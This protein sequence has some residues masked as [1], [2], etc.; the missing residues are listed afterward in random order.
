DLE[1]AGQRQPVGL[2]V[3]ADEQV[4]P[5]HSARLKPRLGPAAEAAV[6]PFTGR[7]RA[8]SLLALIGAPSTYPRPAR[9]E[10]EVDSRGD[11]AEGEHR[12][13]AAELHRRRRHPGDH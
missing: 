5:T 8:A 12:V 9:Y 4:A 13:H 10:L 6:R 11:L 3:D 1:H 7:R 2:A